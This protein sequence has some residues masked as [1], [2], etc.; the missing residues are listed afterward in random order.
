MSILRAAI[1]R[2]W[3]RWAKVDRQVRKWRKR[4]VTTHT[5][6]DA[7]RS[8]APRRFSPGVRAQGTPLSHWSRAEVAQYLAQD[9]TLPRFSASTVGRWRNRRTHPPLALSYL[10]AYP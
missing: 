2:S 10:A 4:W 3:R 8:G 5:L 6:A 7:P 9:P 1:N